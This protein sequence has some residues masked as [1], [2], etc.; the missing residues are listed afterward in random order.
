MKLVVLSVEGLRFAL[1]LNPNRML[2]KTPTS[3]ASYDE[4]ESGALVI[5]PV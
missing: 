5:L 1:T 3:E 2:E 4:P